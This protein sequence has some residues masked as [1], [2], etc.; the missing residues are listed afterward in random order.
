MVVTL[1]T[2]IRIYVDRI[3]RFLAHLYHDPRRISDILR[4]EGLSNDAIRALRR[5]H[6]P[7]YISRLLGEWCSLIAAKLPPRHADI[8]IRRYGLDEQRQ[9]SLW[10]LANRYGV[11]RERIHQLEINAV[12][13]LWS[14]KR[15]RMLE[16][17]ASEIARDILGL[18][19]GQG[20]SL[21]ESNSNVW[22]E[23]KPLPEYQIAP[24]ERKRLPEYVI[25]VRQKHARAYERWTTDEDK[26]LEE[27]FGQGMTIEA[28]ALAFKRKP[29]AIYARL[30]KLG[31]LITA[32]K[33]SR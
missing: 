30:S 12:S 4:A 22:G 16:Q 28:L 6:L 1:H 13:R 31:L 14:G 11:S 5:D 10:A 29:S 15:R 23:Q 19:P 7:A 9:A 2:D 24:R 33:V 20:P 17:K 21:I 8:L 32:A 25:V 18:P 27:Q 3:N 26:S